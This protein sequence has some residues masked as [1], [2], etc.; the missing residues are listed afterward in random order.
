MLNERRLAVETVA[1]AFLPTERAAEQT[2]ILGARCIAAMIEQRGAA[3]LPLDTG[4]EAFALVTD[5]TFHALKARAALINAHQLLATIP[6]SIGIKS[7]GGD[8]CPPNEP[9]T[10]AV[11]KSV[12]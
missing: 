11:L 2:A 12:A 10:S 6:A 9:F 3:G 1:A 8:E 5:A 4:A 7:Y